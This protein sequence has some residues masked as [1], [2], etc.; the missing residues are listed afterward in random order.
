MVAAFFFHLKCQEAA[1]VTTSSRRLGP[2]V[3]HLNQELYQKAYEGGPPVNGET[4]N[5]QLNQEWRNYETK[6]KYND[7]YKQKKES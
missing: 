4:L 1:T 2:K 5:N 3:F 7:L 6:Q